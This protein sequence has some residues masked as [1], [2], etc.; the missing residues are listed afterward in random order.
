MIKFIRIFLF[1]LIIIGL[2]L[3][4]TQKL[5]VP[6]L[7]DRIISKENSPTIL[8]PN[9]DP[10]VGE[11]W[12]TIF[13]VV[14]L[15]PTCPVEMYPPDPKCAD[16]PYATTLALTT[17]DGAKVIK[18]FSSDAAGKFYVEVPPGQY[19]IRSAATANILPYCQNNDTINLSANGSVEVA[20]SCD[21][22]IR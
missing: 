4:A 15:G 16:R 12:G 1:V 5:W 8:P 11:F 19:T 9:D 7:V 10:S 14:M 13:G 18:T 22:G 3:I 6:K 21:T 17:P 2:G 20:V